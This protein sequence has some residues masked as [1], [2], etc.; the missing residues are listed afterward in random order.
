MSGNDMWHTYQNLR[1]L[2]GCEKCGSYKL[3][4]GCLFTVNYVYGCKSET[5]GGGGGGSPYDPFTTSRKLV[6]EIPSELPQRLELPGSPMTSLRPFYQ[7]R[8][9]Y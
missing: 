1:K 5:G 6:E 3:G 7:G 8:P 4:N 9:F 2:G